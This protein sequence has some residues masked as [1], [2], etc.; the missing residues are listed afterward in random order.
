[1]SGFALRTMPVAWYLRCCFPAL[2]K[3]QH[4]PN[5]EIRPIMKLLT[6]SAME[7]IFHWYAKVPLSSVS[8]GNFA[9]HENAR[10]AQYCR[11]GMT[12]VL[13]C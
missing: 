9:F 8:I 7:T 10:N 12:T 3:K 2:S 5:A 13:R 11:E 6:G 4:A 1:M